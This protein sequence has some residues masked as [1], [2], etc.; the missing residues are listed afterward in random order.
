M[1]RPD[2]L[3]SDMDSLSS[4]GRYKMRRRIGSG[5]TGAIYEAHDPI[6]DRRVAI[7]VLRAEFAERPDGSL[8][9]IDRLR[10][11][12]RRASRTGETTGSPGCNLSGYDQFQGCPGYLG[13]E[14]D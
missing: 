8:S 10:Y 6:I 11:A 7:K 3:T 12:T 13:Y 14:A 4:N 2:D 5:V 1:S 9:G